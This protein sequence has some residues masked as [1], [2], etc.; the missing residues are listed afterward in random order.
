[1]AFALLCA[2]P[3]AVDLLAPYAP[4]VECCEADADADCGA[5]QGCSPD[6][7]DCTCCAPP[8]ATLAAAGLFRAL[9]A[10]SPEQPARATHDVDAPGYPLAL[11]RP[12][13]G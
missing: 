8:S 4:G 3:G 13:A 6:C 2:T 12:P 9:P 10:P 5:D 1:M 7:T 11:F